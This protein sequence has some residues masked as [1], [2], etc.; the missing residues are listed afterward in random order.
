MLFMLRFCILCNNIC[1][2]KLNL[3]KMVNMSSEPTYLNNMSPVVSSEYDKSALFN[4][5]V[6]VWTISS[7]KYQRFN[8]CMI[9]VMSKAVFRIFEE[10]GVD[11]L[12]S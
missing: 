4:I 7:N 11:K 2:L 9:C 1:R 6:F 8:D 12:C 3:L 10:K 5:H